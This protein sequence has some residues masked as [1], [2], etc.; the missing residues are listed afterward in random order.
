MNE[1]TSQLQDGRLSRPERFRLRVSAIVAKYSPA[2]A[3]PGWAD[4]PPVLGTSRAGTGRGEDGGRSQV[5]LAVRSGE[6]AKARR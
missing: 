3:W 5:G 6:I 4:T 1:Q 2:G